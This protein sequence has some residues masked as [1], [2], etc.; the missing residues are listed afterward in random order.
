MCCVQGVQEQSLGRFPLP[1]V[2]LWQLQIRMWMHLL[3]VA[4]QVSRGSLGSSCADRF[5]LELL[6]LN[7][8]MPLLAF[9]SITYDPTVETHTF[10]PPAPVLAII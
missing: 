2:F 10:A 3:H 9:K 5:E 6:L 4:P 7:P 1:I 8:H